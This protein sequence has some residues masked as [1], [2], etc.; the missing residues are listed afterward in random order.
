MG[1]PW[2]RGRH[3]GD[4]ICIR[5]R[6]GDRMQTA[7]NCRRYGNR[8][9]LPRSAADKYLSGRDYPDRADWHRS[10]HNRRHPAWLSGSWCI[11]PPCQQNAR[12][13]GIQNSR[14]SGVYQ[15]AGCLTSRVPHPLPGRRPPLLGSCHPGPRVVQPSAEQV[16]GRPRSSPAAWP[17]R[18]H[19]LQGRMP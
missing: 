18:N 12:S 19:P 1:R 4:R 11:P 6:P 14:F 15:P 17:R 7:S 9:T 10:H 3:C 8:C 5:S 13:R 2:G 16:R